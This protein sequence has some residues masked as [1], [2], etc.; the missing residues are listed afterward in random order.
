MYCHRASSIVFWSLER[1][2][3]RITSQQTDMLIISG[4][5]YEDNTEDGVAQ[6]YGHISGTEL[7]PSYNGDLTIENGIIRSEVSIINARSL[8]ENVK[9]YD[10]D[11]LFTGNLKVENGKAVNSDYTFRGEISRS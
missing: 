2:S 10:G 4:V 9:V 6:L 3:M 5:N 11:D 8:A 1:K 7:L